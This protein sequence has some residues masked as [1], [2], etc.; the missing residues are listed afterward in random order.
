[1]AAG[2]NPGG[3]QVLWTRP[4]DHDKI[5]RRRRNLGLYYGL[6][7]LAALILAL[8]LGGPGQAAG[9]LILVGLFGLL[10]GGMVFFKDLNAKM[11]GT[12]KLADGKLVFGQRQVDLA[13]LES[14]TTVS[15]KEDWGVMDQALFGN[16]MAGNAITAKA[17]FRLA[18][19]DESGQ[20]GTNLEGG[21]GYE[22]VEF[23]W[24]EM[25]PEV[26]DDLRKTLEPHLFAPWVPLDQLR[27]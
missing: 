24:A 9:V 8:V 18:H 27:G 20:R 3:D 26:L 7:S 14:W 11:G 15:M 2:D 17:L 6:P 16:P 25:T 12:I 19:Y 23:A 13:R 5:A 1:M 22:V 21:P 4:I 10:V